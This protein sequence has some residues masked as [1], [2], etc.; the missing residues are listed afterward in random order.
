MRKQLTKFSNQIK[1]SKE[2]AS[3]LLYAWSYK[4]KDFQK[5]KKFTSVTEELQINW[6]IKLIQRKLRHVKEK[7]SYELSCAQTFLQRSRFLRER[8]S[9][10]K[11]AKTFL[12]A[13]FRH[14]FNLCIST[15][16]IL[17]SEY[18]Q[19]FWK[20]ILEVIQRRAAITIQRHYRGFEC[21]KKYSY[22]VSMI[23][24]AKRRFIEKR[25]ATD[26]QRVTRGSALRKKLK[27]FKKGTV[28]FQKMFRRKLN[29]SAYL[30]LRKSTIKIQRFW[31]RYAFRMFKYEFLIKEK[32]DSGEYV[33]HKDLAKKELQQIFSANY[34]DYIKI[35][36]R[37][38]KCA[39]R[40]SALSFV[41]TLKP[42]SPPKFRLF[43]YVLDIDPV[44]DPND[45]FLSSWAMTFMLYFRH[46]RDDYE[47]NLMHLAVGDSHSL[48]VSDNSY[49]Y[50]WGSSDIFQ[51]AKFE[52]FMNS[53]PREIP[54]KLH[55]HRINYV[56]TGSNHTLLYSKSSGTLYAYGDNE[57]GQ[58]GLGH[59]NM[60]KGIIN[61]SHLLKGKKAVHIE[62][63][64]DSNIICLED[65]T[66]I[67]W[68]LQVRDLSFPEPQR[69]R[70]PNEKIKFVS[71]GYDFTMF[72]TANG[73]VYS[74]GK[75]GDC[76]E[77]GQGDF[78]PREEPTLIK[79]LHQSGEM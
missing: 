21:R 74:M 53:N 8:N 61:L 2:R 27:K 12:L 67:A 41:P 58:L 43:S 38:A 35:S 72:L 69:I 44:V 24:L 79:K 6:R 59:Y 63:K 9:M 50:H 64:V 30:Q 15:K 60:V 70:I 49:I 34:V 73:R 32:I 48:A 75:S 25:A 7:R 62:S 71:L 66:V 37:L 40:D 51:L 42:F 11:I 57:K 17:E 56:Q 68:P 16:K 46:L 28:Y 31:R 4:F 1:R 77:L 47:G 45:T 19:R 18:D 55:P 33:V 22:E 76:G 14:F 52:P 65:G 36:E 20:G 3:S 26:I 78:A 54:M 39:K 13:R 29:R 10:N 23:K 5:Y